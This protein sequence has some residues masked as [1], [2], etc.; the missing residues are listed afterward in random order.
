MK[1]LGKKHIQYL[2]DS[3][4]IK[5]FIKTLNSL[6]L[7]L[8]EGFLKLPKVKKDNK[9]S[10]KT[11]IFKNDNVGLEKR[12]NK[13]SKVVDDIDINHKMRVKE[14]NFVDD[15]ID[16]NVI[17]PKLNNDIQLEMTQVK[18]GFIVHDTD[19]SVKRKD[20]QLSNG[21]VL[22]KVTEGLSDRDG[23][24]KGNFDL[25]K[26]I[27]R[28]KDG[29]SLNNKGRENYSR[30]NAPKGSSRTPKKSLEGLSDGN[31]LFDDNFGS[32][33]VIDDIKDDVFLNI[34]GREN[35]S[36][37]NS[38]KDTFETSK[39]QLKGLS[40]DDDFLNNNFDLVKMIN[41]IKDG[42]SLSINGREN[43]ASDNSSKDTSGNSK[44][45]LKGILKRSSSSRLDLLMEVPSPPPIF[46]DATT[47]NNQLRR[48]NSKG[49]NVS[50]AF[51]L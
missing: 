41:F 26:V 4:K 20:D 22:P 28:I 50:F 2:D 12:H 3:P 48:A 45:P 21:F 24:L 11:E 13:E 14:G 36:N 30:D 39:I 29:V 33:K 23:L 16:T 38:S 5:S 43:Y 6:P 37:D 31:G 15:I 40:G 19:K 49:R 25:A 32:V 47:P 35:Y 44:T 34:E 18:K 27:N 17:S 10:R 1:L 46:K 51:K 9:S 7:L 42:R 8:S